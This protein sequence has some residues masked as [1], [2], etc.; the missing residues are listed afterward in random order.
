M[1]ECFLV[2]LTV[3]ETA[4]WP[5]ISSSSLVLHI[6]TLWYCFFSDMLCKYTYSGWNVPAVTE[7]QERHLSCKETGSNNSLKSEKILLIK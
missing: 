5:D 3:G 7:L 4:K 6:L 1:S 2:M